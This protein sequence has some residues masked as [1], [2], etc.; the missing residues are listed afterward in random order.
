MRCATRRQPATAAQERNVGLHAGLVPSM[1]FAPVGH[2]S[3]VAVAEEV[4]RWS[5]Q[6]RMHLVPVVEAYILQ[7]RARDVFEGAAPNPLTKAVH[8]LRTR[9][10]IAMLAYLVASP[11]GAGGHSKPCPAAFQIGL[12]RPTAGGAT[13]VRSQPLT[14]PPAGGRLPPARASGPPGT[15]SRNAASLRRPTGP[16]PRRGQSDAHRS[17]RVCRSGLCRGGGGASDRAYCV[18]PVRH[19]AGTRGAHVTDTIKIWLPAATSQEHPTETVHATAVGDDR[20]RINTVTLDADASLGDVVTVSH[21]PGHALP[22]AMQ[23]V[24]RADRVTMRLTPI[25]R[26]P[27]VR[28]PA[29]AARPRWGAVVATIAGRIAAGPY[30][31]H[32]ALEIRR[33][34]SDDVEIL[35]SVVADVAD[36]FL[37]WVGQEALDLLGVLDTDVWAYFKTWYSDDNTTSEQLEENYRAYSTGPFFVGDIADPSLPTPWRLDWSRVPMPPTAPASLPY[38]LDTDTLTRTWP[39][40]VRARLNDTVAHGDMKVYRMARDRLFRPA[41]HRVLIDE[42]RYRF[43][44]PPEIAPPAWQL[45]SPATEEDRVAYHA[46]WAA[47]RAADGVVRYSS[48]L[49]AHAY[50]VD[51]MRACG[52]DPN[53]DPYTPV[54]APEV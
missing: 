1:T 53:A 19:H 50:M 52:L 7:L 39:A 20:W 45:Q 14:A 30:G 51:V 38:D 34:T 10:V 44:N 37:I 32:V 35:V 54:H 18:A 23:I 31:E 41:L 21:N 9:D 22:R 6:R 43:N 15:H 25:D 33:F 49:D 11:D 27:V 47:A 4:A 28:S 40:E 17:N 26:H 3:A 12:A 2:D 24:E 5:F 29:L 36:A 8:V 13:A 46:E 42:L 16:V 48:M